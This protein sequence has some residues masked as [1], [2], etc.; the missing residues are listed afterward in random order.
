MIGEILVIIGIG[1]VIYLGYI[2]KPAH[3]PHWRQMKKEKV[4]CLRAQG[5]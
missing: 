1:V 5:Y 4:L 3:K 2:F